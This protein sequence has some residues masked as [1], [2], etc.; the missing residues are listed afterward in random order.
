[1]RNKKTN[2]RASNGCYI[3]FININNDRKFEDKK[4]F[5]LYIYQVCRFSSIASEGYHPVISS[6]S[7][8]LS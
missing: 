2:E 8:I 1:M 4:F 7:D 3:K 5:T 6:F